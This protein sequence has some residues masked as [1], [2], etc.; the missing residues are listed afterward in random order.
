M[1]RCCDTRVNLFSCVLSFNKTC[2]FST[3]K[4]RKPW[5]QPMACS[6]L[7]MNRVAT[8]LLH[9]LVY[10]LVVSYIFR[11]LCL[12][13]ILQSTYCIIVQILPSSKITEYLCLNILRNKGCGVMM[14]A[15]FNR[16]SLLFFVI[17]TA[18]PIVCYSPI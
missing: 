1:Q 9:F 11:I 8:Y 17:E 5:N 14:K 3:A 15:L 10:D 18:S 6:F 4:T 13:L 2:L 16:I 12:C 7:Q